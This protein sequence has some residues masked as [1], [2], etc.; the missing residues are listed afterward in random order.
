MRKHL[1]VTAVFGSLFISTV[2]K[3]DDIELNRH[4]TS[5]PKQEI[6]KSERSAVTY[7]SDGSVS[8]WDHY[9]CPRGGF[10]CLPVLP[11]K[12]NPDVWYTAGPELS[13]LQKIGYS[14]DDTMGAYTEDGEFGLQGFKAVLFNNIGQAER[15]CQELAYNNYAGR[16]DWRLG[17]K[18]EIKGLWTEYK[19]ASKGLFTAKFWPTA[20][21]YWT[22]TKVLGGSDV[23]GVFMDAGGSRQHDPSIPSYVSCVSE[24]E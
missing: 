17:T 23:F 16:N 15:W 13:Y 14:N 9:P 21:R 7:E 3:A 11:S 18:D 20:Y 5:S 1:L 6:P 24:S 8:V 12:K 2:T 10:A 4:K 22:S 19:F